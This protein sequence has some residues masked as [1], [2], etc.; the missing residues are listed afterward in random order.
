MSPQAP[1][2]RPPRAVGY[3]LT[4][5]LLVLALGVVTFPHPAAA[6][7]RTTTETGA[8]MRWADPT[9]PVVV[10]LGSPPRSLTRSQV[11]NAVLGAAGVWSSTA[12]TC[13]GLSLTVHGNEEADGPAADDRINRI[14]FRRELWRRE[15]CSPDKPQDCTVYDSSA[16]AVTSVLAV[17][18][19]GEIVDSDMEINAVD[20]VWGDLGAGPGAGRLDDLQN[21][22]THELGHLIGLDHNCTD[23]ATRGVPVDHLGGL[24]PPC[25]QA[26][27]ELQAATMFNQAGP[28][29]V[30][31]RTLSEDD[32]RA[33]CEVYP[34]GQGIVNLGSDGVRESGGCNLPRDLTGD[35]PGRA[36]WAG[37]L[38][39][40]LGLVALTRRRRRR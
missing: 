32:A 11:V 40:L 20:R 29:D 36:S 10:Y 25:V 38:L 3:L 2:G 17:R 21:T 33:V 8:P 1:P 16:L 31:K 34:A 4:R 7:V 35:R 13:T 26:S 18:R 23:A 19:T 37:P 27:A 9:V 30:G 15:P 6:Y 12:L 39:A 28:G 14:T 22:L 5:V 24:A